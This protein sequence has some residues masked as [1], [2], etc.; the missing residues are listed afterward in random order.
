MPDNHG[1]F[2]LLQA[3][4]ALP[5]KCTGCGRATDPRGFIDTGYDADFWGVIY[6]CY[7]C[8]LDMASK[9]GFAGPDV[10]EQM[11]NR[12]GELEVETTSQRAAI[13]GLEDTVDGLLRVRDSGAS[14]IT[15]PTQSDTSDK[16]EVEETASEEIPEDYRE[17]V[18]E[19][20]DYTITVGDT[21]IND[22]VSESGAAGISDDDGLASWAELSI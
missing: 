17:P 9:F 12:I 7:E 5:G 20:T 16:P 14:N 2:T 11:Q 1:Q 22:D 4:S 19:D 21:E 18:S 8:V 10:V 6:Y 13:L 3:P 15:V